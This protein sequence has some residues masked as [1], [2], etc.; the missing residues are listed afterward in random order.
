[1]SDDAGL[2]S[3][4]LGHENVQHTADLNPLRTGL[5]I[6]RIHES[7][8]PGEGIIG[9]W[10][11]VPIARTSAHRGIRIY[12]SAEPAVHRLSSLVH[13][14]LCRSGIAKR[15]AY[16]AGSSSHVS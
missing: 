4:Q 11:E 3:T 1:M 10:R 6:L 9:D 16:S 2:N 15:R 13:D 8:N 12:I 5:E 7:E 14:W